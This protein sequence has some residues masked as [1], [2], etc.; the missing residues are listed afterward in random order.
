MIQRRRGS[1]HDSSNRKEES[2]NQSFSASRQVSG[3][4]GN[5]DI[6]TEPGL[7]LVE[8]VFLLGLKDQQGY[9]S[10][11]NDT[12]S[13]ILRGCILMELSF[14]G[15][16]RTIHESYKRHPA[17][18]HLEVIDGSSTC[19]GLLDEA[20]RHIK[21]E[22]HSVAGWIDL[23]SGETW[24]PLKSHFQLKQVRERTAKGLVDKGVLRTDKKDFLLFDMA[25]HPLLN[26]N[27]KISLTTKIQN[28]LTGHTN[29]LDPSS[30]TTD[31]RTVALICSALVGNVLGSALKQL[32]P[33][34]RESSRSKAEAWLRDYCSEEVSHNDIVSGV[35]NVFIRMDTLLY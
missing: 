21:S 19:D 26:S 10:F 8:Q 6:Q 2:R 13:Y 9:L 17:E 3:D 7:T 5:I 30:P 31:I 24:N 16:I 29:S 23:L 22:R 35:L 4:R 1:P 12:I 32:S 25:T 27:V 28:V 20:L 34:Q 15:K 33:L 18:R 11:L 14:Q